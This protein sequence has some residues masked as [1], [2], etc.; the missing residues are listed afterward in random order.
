MTAD[1]ARFAVQGSSGR[2]SGRIISEVR[3]SKPTGGR[4]AKPPGTSHRLGMAWRRRRKIPQPGSGGR[5]KER[6]AGPRPAGPELVTVQPE[7]T[8][9][10]R[11]RNIRRACYILPMVDVKPTA[12]LRCPGGPGGRRDLVL[13][14]ARS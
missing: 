2:M 4:R 12:R 9:L 13:P 10:S 6:G 1:W 8:S 14:P 5:C 11:V 3:G 7:C